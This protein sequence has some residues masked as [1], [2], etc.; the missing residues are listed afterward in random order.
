MDDRRDDAQLLAATGHDGHA[1]VVFYDRYESMIVSYLCRRI[2]VSELVA[3]LTA[4]VF[5]AALQAAGRY[6]PEHP[7]AGPW[8]IRIAHNTLARS[9]RRSRVESR[10]RRRLGIREPVS[11]VDQE[12]DRVDQLTGQ[13]A[14]ELL[15]RLPREQAEAIRERILKER[16]YPDIAARLT[17]SE[18]VVRKR[19]SRGLDRLRCQLSKENS[20]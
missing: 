10:A 8:L 4:E 6:R 11:F 12:L 18:L 17:T 13:S 15:G 5:A 9:I 14:E 1:F 3:D 2:S 7:T 20:R 16:S 19:V